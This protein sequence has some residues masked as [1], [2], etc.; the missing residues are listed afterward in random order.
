MLLSRRT[1]RAWASPA[2]PGRPAWLR[3]S[4]ALAKTLHLETS[5]TH[6]V[7]LVVNGRRPS[8]FAAIACARLCRGPVS[9]RSPLRDWPAQCPGACAVQNTPA[10]LPR[11]WARRTSCSSPRRR[12]WDHGDA[13]WGFSHRDRSKLAI[14]GRHILGADAGLAGTPGA[15]GSRWALACVFLADVVSRRPSRSPPQ[16]RRGARAAR[17][18]KAVRTSPGVTRRRIDR[19]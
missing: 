15:A 13:R 9:P 16:V 5:G 1:R 12:E 2:L 10:R 17:G 6:R 14:V 4:S 7:N 11:R 19:R 18:G 8:L 3:A